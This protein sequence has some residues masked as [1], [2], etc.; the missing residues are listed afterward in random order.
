M[1]RKRMLKELGGRTAVRTGR[2]CTLIVYDK[3]AMNRAPYTYAA[4]MSA[5]SGQWSLRRRPNQ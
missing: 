1:L 3:D 5:V 4:D 2:E